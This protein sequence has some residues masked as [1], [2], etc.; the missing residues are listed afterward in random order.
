MDFE[1]LTINRL[2]TPLVAAT[3]QGTCVAFNNAVPRCQAAG[4]AV[5][6]YLRSAFWI[7]DRFRKNEN[8]TEMNRRP[9]TYTAL[10]N[11]Q[12]VFCYSDGKQIILETLDERS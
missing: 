9:N 11:G 3:R 12:H 6:G 10:R 8:T 7:C 5:R 2:L 4:V 1:S